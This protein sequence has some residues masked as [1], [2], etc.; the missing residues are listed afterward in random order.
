MVPISFFLFWW[1][2]LNLSPSSFRGPVAWVGMGI[3]AFLRKEAPRTGQVH[4]NLLVSGPVL[5]RGLISWICLTGTSR[6]VAEKQGML[7]ATLCSCSKDSNL[8]SELVGEKHRF[9]LT[10]GPRQSS[11]FSTS[12]FLAQVWGTCELF[13]RVTQESL[14][15]AAYKNRRGQSRKTRATERG[16]GWTRDLTGSR[17]QSPQTHS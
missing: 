7:I 13:F 12:V 16:R 14:A 9:I 2:D 8:H 1:R 6:N 4:E 11:C 15:L 3:W 10:S 5:P 17:T